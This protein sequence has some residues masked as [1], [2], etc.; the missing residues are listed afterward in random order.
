MTP[1]FQWKQ[2]NR[3][4]IDRTAGPLSRD[5]G[6]QPAERHNPSGEWLS[7]QFAACSA[8]HAD[9]LAPARSSSE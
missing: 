9:R 6:I 8:E 5:A 2:H 4:P 7:P 3:G 1:F